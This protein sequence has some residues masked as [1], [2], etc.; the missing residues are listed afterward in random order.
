MDDIKYT[1]RQLLGYVNTMFNCDGPRKTILFINIWKEITDGKQPFELKADLRDRYN[2]AINKAWSALVRIETSKRNDRV[3][4][5]A[6]DLRESFMILFAE[7]F[8]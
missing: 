6:K 1:G 8:K 7:F 3:D 2:E 5:A 4:R